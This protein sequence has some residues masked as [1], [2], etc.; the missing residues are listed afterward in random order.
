MPW[1]PNCSS[2]FLM[3]SS[4]KDVFGVVP[5]T[6]VAVTVT[7]VGLLENSPD[8]SAFTVR[9]TVAGLTPSRLTVD[10]LKLH[11]T[12]VGRFEQ[13]SCTGFAKLPCGMRSRVTLPE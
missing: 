13:V 7:V 10:L 11:V 1:T 8:F 2:Y 6:L 9:E 5:A 3:V 12:S 4:S